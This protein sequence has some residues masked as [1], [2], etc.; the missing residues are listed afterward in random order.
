MAA[1]AVAAQPLSTQATHGAATGGAELGDASAESTAAPA[2]P[3]QSATTELVQTATD[4]LAAPPPASAAIK[5]PAVQQQRSNEQLIAAHA[6]L[7]RAWIQHWS[8]IS[9]REEGP[10]SQSWTGDSWG[11][12]LHRQ[13]HGCAASVYGCSELQASKERVWET[14]MADCRAALL[15]LQEAKHTTASTQPTPERAIELIHPAAAIEFEFQANG[16]TSTE[17]IAQVRG[18][19]EAAQAERDRREWNGQSRTFGDAAVRSWCDRASQLAV[20]AQQFELAAA[21]SVGT[22]E[23]ILSA[24]SW[25]HRLVDKQYSIFLRELESASTTVDESARWRQMKEVE[26][27]HERLKGFLLRIRARERRQQFTTSKDIRAKE[28]N[29]QALERTEGDQISERT[30]ASDINA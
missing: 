22:I 19:V 25:D 8:T 7:H 9:E 14:A 10:H 1:D 18:F 6:A 15:Q 17:G 13:Q 24:Q 4:Q 29:D 27:K 11:Q 28:H 26:M 16:T 20:I 12:E 2:A 30:E 5:Q 3:A 21:E 23:E